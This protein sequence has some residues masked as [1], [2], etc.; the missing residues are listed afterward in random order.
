LVNYL[1][2]KA[3]DV[4]FTMIFK[5]GLQPYLRLVENK[6]IRDA[7]IKHKESIVMCE[8]SELVIANCNALS[9]QPKSKPVAQPLINYIITK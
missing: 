8:E 5:V 6:M 9:T 1:Q 4:L 3:I 2:I 7:L